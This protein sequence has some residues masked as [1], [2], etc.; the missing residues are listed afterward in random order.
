MLKKDA[1]SSM[2][3]TA[4]SDVDH[5]ALELLR[6]QLQ[7]DLELSLD[8]HA[9]ILRSAEPP[10]WVQFFA[11]APW[12]IKALEAYAALYVAE[13][14]KAAGKETWKERAKLTRAAV[15]TGNKVLKL[16]RS[17][18][19]LRDR[20]PKK[21]KLVLGLPV[22]DDYFGTRFELIGENEN[23]I[24]AEIA[25]FIRYVPAIE[26]IIEAEGLR[27]GKVTGAITLR[28]A[29]DSSLRVTWMNRESLKIEDR[30]LHLER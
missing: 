29:E 9:I 21:T 11:E 17:F 1:V 8:E 18:V 14:V 13:I 26:R 3:A 28:I 4:T 7:P 2:K 15:G 20:I 6:E 10:S 19:A 12:W 16:A 24:A 30:T 5:A 27:A 25:L 22:P 23:I